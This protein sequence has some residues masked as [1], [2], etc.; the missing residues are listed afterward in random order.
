MLV[1]VVALLAVIVILLFTIFAVVAYDLEKIFV[2]I[3]EIKHDPWDDLQK[4]INKEEGK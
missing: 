4:Q 3:Q 2:A 1:A